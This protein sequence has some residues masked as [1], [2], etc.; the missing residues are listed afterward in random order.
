MA[1]RAIYKEVLADLETPLTAYLKVAGQPS[2]LLESVEQGERVAR[3]S[4]IGSGQ[5]RRI[6]AYSSKITLV[7]PQGVRRFTSR[8]PLRALWE[9]SVR[10]VIPEPN[11]RPFWL[12]SVGY[13]SYDIVRQY[14]RLPDRNPDE[15]NVPDL[16][17]IE[18]EALVIFDHLKRRLFIVVGAAT[19]ITFNPEGPFSGDYTVI[20][21]QV[22]NWV[23][24]PQ[25][26]FRVLAAAG[27]IVLLGVLL[28]MNAFAI[29]LRNRYQRRW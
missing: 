14:E 28:L 15:L 16:L 19:F 25:D 29:W 24:Q 7:T 22:F 4:F 3:Y 20:P 26:E 17:F 8:D 27:I 10:E 11:L 23:R 9:M 6:D 13:A 18:P 5:R 12:G 21:V 1:I 2:F